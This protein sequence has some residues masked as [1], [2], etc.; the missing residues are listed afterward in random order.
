M[1]FTSPGGQERACC[2]L[3][4]SDWLVRS[5]KLN[6]CQECGQMKQVWLGRCQKPGLGSSDLG[7]EGG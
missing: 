7:E 2:V 6:G 5:D 3:G 4:T 1:G